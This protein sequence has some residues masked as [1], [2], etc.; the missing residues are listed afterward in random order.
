MFIVLAFLIF[1]GM[2]GGL[3]GVPISQSQSFFS[4]HAILNDAA[5]NTQW[6]FIFNYVHFKTLDDSNPFQEMPTQQANDILKEIYATPQDTTIQVLNTR[7]PNVI[8]VLL[9][10]WSGDCIATLGGRDSITP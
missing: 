9:E 10:S 4:Q 2:R 3:K 7:K 5:V 6:N 8:F 1:C